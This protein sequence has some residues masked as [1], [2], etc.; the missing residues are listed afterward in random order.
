[1]TDTLSFS[2]ARH[3]QMNRKKTLPS[4]S[5]K[6]VLHKTRVTARKN[7]FAGRLFPTG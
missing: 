4:R 1:M 2:H 3:A 6:P 5:I 7:R